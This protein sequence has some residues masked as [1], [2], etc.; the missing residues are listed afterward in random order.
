MKSCE[1]PNCVGAIDGKHVVTQAPKN[2]GSLYFNY[3]GTHSVVLLAV[4]DARY[5]FLMVDIGVA[6]RL[7]DG[8]VLSRS[9]FGQALGNSLSLPQSKPLPGLPSTVSYVFVGDEA[10]PLKW[11]MMHPYPDRNLPQPQAVYNYY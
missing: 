6:G 11:N 3:K 8:V 2:A 7:S 1:T 10:F 4:C 9:K 5:R